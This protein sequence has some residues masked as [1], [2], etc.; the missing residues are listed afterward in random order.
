MCIARGIKK[1]NNIGTA[2]QS[3][4]R[5]TDSMVFRKVSESHVCKLVAS[6]K[7][8]SRCGLDDISN[9]L[10][11]NIISVIK[12]PL[13]VIINKSLSEGNFP[14]LMKIAKVILLHKGGE[15]DAPDNFRPISL[16]PVLSK[17]L[18]CVA[19][20]QTVEF[21]DKNKLIYSRQYGFRKWHATSDAIMNLTGDILEAL[22]S[23]LM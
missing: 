8:E 3:V 18:E 23:N 12:T 14:D 5:N 10:L 21:L 11:K 17:V 16:L 13:T 1:K 6:M 22:D 19:Y 9:A 7:P 2:V 20:N 15:L 4:Q